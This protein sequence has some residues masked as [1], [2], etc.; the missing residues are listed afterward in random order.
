M[1]YMTQPSPYVILYHFIELDDILEIC[2]IL[3]I[4]YNI[5]H[6]ETTTP[7][8]FFI[9]KIIETLKTVSEDNKKQLIHNFNFAIR[10]INNPSKELIQLHNMIWKV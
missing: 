4:S 6:L 9:P 1:E 7:R 10:I 3:D 5:E 8:K 2:D